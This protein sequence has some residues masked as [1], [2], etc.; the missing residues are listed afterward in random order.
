MNANQLHIRRAE[1]EDANK[2]FDLYKTVSKILGGL[3]RTETEITKG[4]QL[5][6]AVFRHVLS[7]LTIAVDPDYQGKGLGKKLFQTLLAD[8][9]SNRTEIL[10]VELIARETNSRA[11]QL[12]EKLG[13]KIEG[14][15]E[16][17]ISNNSISFEADIPMAW[18]PNA[19]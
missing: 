2:I 8:V 11:I 12:Y 13:F 9:Q 3:A 7:E 5:E 14:R 6:P 19:I 4:Y 18:F 16:K 15:F 10:R 17:R 1:L